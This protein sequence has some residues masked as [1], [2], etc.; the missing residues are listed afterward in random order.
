MAIA[1]G[2][3]FVLLIAVS[4]V[5]L[6]AHTPLETGFGLAIG[7][8]ALAVFTRGYLSDRPLAA[9]LRPLML[10]AAVLIV[11]MHGRQLHA[12]DLL[13]T[14]GIYLQIGAVACP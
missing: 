12:E 7:V 9:P 14:I 6:G 8:G 13:H 11:F 4:R 2:I 5:V 3:A 1:G 10:A